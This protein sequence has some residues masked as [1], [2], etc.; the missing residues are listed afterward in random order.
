MYHSSDTL[1]F[2]YRSQVATNVVLWARDG[3]IAIR[4]SG[5]KFIAYSL[6]LVSV[7][8]LWISLWLFK[9]SLQIAVSTPVSLADY[10]K[11]RLEY[12]RLTQIFEKSNRFNF[13]VQI[14][15]APWHMKGVLRIVRDIFAVIRQRRDAIGRALS[16]LDAS[17]PRTDIL[18]PISEKDIWNARIPVYDY[19]F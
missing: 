8:V 13:S 3:F 2:V 11:A 4:K 17:A 7:G 15:N 1:L 5:G 14:R 10:K 6:A 19:R 18:T 16:Q 9:R 12:D